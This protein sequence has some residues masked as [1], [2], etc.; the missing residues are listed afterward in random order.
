MIKDLESAL[1]EIA[2]DISLVGKTPVYKV[3]GSMNNP[4]FYSKS[5]QAVDLQKG[6]QLTA[7]FLVARRSLLQL[8]LNRTPQLILN[9]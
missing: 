2:E 3:L 6:M 7:K 9:N 5:N 4:K 1:I 8:I